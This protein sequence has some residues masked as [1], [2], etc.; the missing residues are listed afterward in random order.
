MKIQSHFFFRLS[1]N[2]TAG[3]ITFSHV[4]DV[5]LSLT[6]TDTCAFVNELKNVVY[7]K[8]GTSIAVAMDLALQEIKK[9]AVN[10]LTLVCKYNY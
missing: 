3:L 1:A 8:G 4:A 5:D 6:Y 7:T 2:R 10:D 9:N